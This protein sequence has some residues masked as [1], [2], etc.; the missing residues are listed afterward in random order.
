LDGQ[1]GGVR[2]KMNITTEW[3][4]KNKACQEGVELFLSQSETDGEKLVH[5]LIGMENLNYA[6]WLIVRLMEYKQ[7][8][9]YALFAVEQVID[10]Y[11][12]IY[13]EFWAE[14]K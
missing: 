12:Q 2:T 14:G 9:S 13:R 4:K 5:K 3:L 7:Q 8:V 6:N 11:E 10:I 1:A